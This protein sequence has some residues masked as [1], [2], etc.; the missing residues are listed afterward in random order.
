MSTDIKLRLA[1]RIGT[2]GFVRAGARARIVERLF[3]WRHERDAP[4]D[5][6]FH[7]Y[8]Y[9]GNLGNF[10][11]FYVFVFGGYEAA[12]LALLEALSSEIP[13]CRAFDVGASTGQH[14]LVLSS[15]CRQVHAFEPFARSREIAAR[16]IAENGIENVELLPFGLGTADESLP[17]YWD[18]RNTNQMA[19]SFVP[20]HANLELFDTLEVRHGDQW[21]ASAGIAGIDLMKIDVEGFEGEV[22]AG[23]GKLLESRPLIMLEISWTSYDRI[24]VL[25]GLDALIPYPHRKFEVASGRD[26]LL[27]DFSGYE[28]WPIAELRRP[29][30]VGYNILIVPDDRMKMRSVT[31]HIRSR[32]ARR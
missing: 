5:V 28:L 7:G 26:A 4:F 8:R 16:R 2:C 24:A 6:E 12:E 17:Y 29:V 31:R 11:D 22:L 20:S 32:A 13:G 3:P 15:R 30:D 9:R 25:G 19:G 18:D 1:R 27:F 23:L 10:Q 21:A 14:M